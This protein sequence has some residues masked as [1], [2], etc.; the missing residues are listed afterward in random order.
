MIKI[1]KASRRSIPVMVVAALIFFSE[2]A[3]S[4]WAQSPGPEG[5][6]I[7]DIKLIS[8]EIW[9][10]AT[11]YGGVYKTSDSG[12]NW[13]LVGDDI[14]GV[15]ATG[16]ATLG[17]N[18]VVATENGVYRSADTGDTWAYA[19]TGLTDTELL[20]VATIGSEFWVGYTGG[21]ST[22][23]DGS[24]WSALGTGIASSSEINSFSRD[25]SDPDLLAA[26]SDEG[27]YMT[28]DGGATWGTVNVTGAPS[29]DFSS[30]SFGFPDELVVTDFQGGS[31]FSD[32]AGTTWN[33]VGG[34]SPEGFYRVFRGPNGVYAGT[35]DG[36]L[37]FAFEGSTW[38]QAF[39]AFPTNINVTSF[40]AA[41]VSMIGTTG[42]VFRSV[43]F[44]DSWVEINSGINAHK[45]TDFKVSG[46]DLYASTYGGGV[47]VSSDNGTTWTA[48]NNGLAGLG[49]AI[50]TL[51]SEISLILAGTAHGVYKSTNDGDSWTAANTGL[52]G[53]PI[54]KIIAHG[55]DHYALELLGGVKKSTDD[56]VSWTGASG[57]TGNEISGIPVMLAEDG[58]N[59]YTGNFF[60]DIVS[61]SSDSGDTWTA[62]DNGIT[63]TS[64]FNTATYIYA[65]GG[66]IYTSTAEGFFK[67]A[68][69]GDSWSAAGTGLP[70][71]VAGHALLSLEAL[72]FSVEGSGVYMSDDLGDNFTAYNTGLNNLSTGPLVVKASTLFV[73]TNGSGV[74]GD[75]VTFTPSSAPDAPVAPTFGTITNS[76]IVVNWA[77][78]NDNGSAITSYVLEQKLGSGGDFTAIFT[79]DALTF[80]STGLASNQEYFYRVKATN[81]IGSSSYS[82][83]ASATTLAG[84]PSKP[85]APTFGAITSTSIVVNWAAPADN[86]SAITSYVLEQKQGVGG[87]FSEVF[88][89][90]GLTHTATSLTDNQEYF[91]RVKAVNSVG[92]SDFS[93]EASQVTTNNVAP[94]V[95]SFSPANN[96]VAV[97]VES[98]L[99]LTFNESIQ[100]GTGNIYI[101]SGVDGAVVETI[102]VTSDKVTISGAA[103]TL[104]PGA[105]LPFSTL[106]Y[107]LIDNTAFEDLE[108]APYAGI[109][110]TSVWRFTTKDEFGPPGKPASP[111]YDNITSKSVRVNFVKPEDNCG[112]CE[113][114]YTVFRSLGGVNIKNENGG[115]FNADTGTL[116]VGGLS[117]DTEYAFA[118]TVTTEYGSASSDPASVTTKSNGV[119]VIEAQSF[120]I[121]ENRSNSEVIGLIAASDPDDDILTYSITAG[122]TGDAF[123]LNGVNSLY[124]HNSTALDYETNPVFNLTVEVSDGRGG[125]SSAIVTV[126]LNDLGPAI[127]D[128][129]F[130]IDENAP[131][132]TTVGNL[133]ATTG[134]GELTFAILDG[135]TN[136]AFTVS[137]LAPFISRLTVNN[138]L[139]LDFEVTPSF[140]LT[141]EVSDGQGGTATAIVTVNLNDVNEVV[142]PENSPPVIANQSFSVPENS[143]EGIGLGTIAASDPDDDPLTYSISSG[144]V[145]DA[146]EIN[147]SHDLIVKSSAA[148][149]FETT[150]VFELVVEVSD[151]ELSAS[152]T[153]TIN[154][155]DVEETETGVEDFYDGR[156]SIYPNPTKGIVT[157]TSQ[158]VKLSH[159]N[160]K[161]VNAAGQ[162][163]PTLVEH[164]EAKSVTVNLLDSPAGIYFLVTEIEGAIVVKR[165]FKN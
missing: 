51:H 67:S 109:S 110:S 66:S 70:G 91:Y 31:F 75:G 108:G 139:A 146:F 88:N 74:W 45:V 112:G 123:T 7:V 29:Q 145:G 24:S 98:A 60:G 138:T 99:V 79:G 41:D 4:Q 6:D 101:K 39:E 82:S 18:I 59:L 121:D 157:I 120:T 73:G 40:Y 93:T 160:F 8:T 21:I 81:A 152:A 23:A 30:V 1:T 163:F 147:S 12:D 119:P 115:N 37:L 14:L 47:F 28:T 135:N 102:D 69:L 149:D 162:E 129:T 3:Y 32:D 63:N 34:L 151:G 111:T 128:Q 42:G 58:V 52:S 16:I 64:G 35:T 53:L 27:L 131:E 36:L 65:L 20:S 83:E 90:N 116:T 2:S 89:G 87:A 143:P 117:P 13:T 155:I 76:S 80:A 118:V 54:S 96:A 144:N 49:L 114:T 136:D 78:P 142:E 92:S 100:K 95:S 156:I 94:T 71:A 124:A 140:S 5:G 55:D 48:K 72:F 104:Q 9:I 153:I 127:G 77:A 132:G 33:A 122:N 61:K 43:D 137:K 105:N 106:L 38:V 25:G 134:D 56:G 15:E 44:G 11:R 57:T 148:L 26:A 154:L 46:S 130:T 165:L 164:H 86:G 19:N 22:S 150:P 133:V 141:M 126:N 107:V 161:V 17:T 85:A 68:S 62:A 84:P 113:M 97:E 159:F 158:G 103:A 10:S 125:T 50:L